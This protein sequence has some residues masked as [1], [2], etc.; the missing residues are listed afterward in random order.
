[1]K[2]IIGAVLMDGLGGPPLSGSVVVIS[3]NRIRAAGA[4]SAI[5][6]P[7]EADKVDGSGRYL[8]PALVAVAPNIQGQGRSGTDQGPRTPATRDRPHRHLG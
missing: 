7:A 4:A 8:I 3:G 1:M 6:I 2:V 5:P